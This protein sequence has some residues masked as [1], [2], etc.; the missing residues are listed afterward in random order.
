MEKRQNKTQDKIREQPA[1]KRLFFR[2][3]TMNTKCEA[4]DFSL[5]WSLK[6]HA[7]TAI[8]T[9][10]IM[11]QFPIEG[12]WGGEIKIPY[13]VTF[14][15]QFHRPSFL[16][17]PLE[18][19]LGCVLEAR[20]RKNQCVFIQFRFGAEVCGTKLSS[21]VYCCFLLCRGHDWRMFMS[22]ENVHYCFSCFVHDKVWPDQFFVLGSM[23]VF[24]Y[25]FHR[26]T[27]CGGECGARVARRTCRIHWTTGI[28]FTCDCFAMGNIKI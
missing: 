24:P 8:N 15:Q 4:Q 16:F 19:L 10:D 13:P 20:K 28:A 23:K 11:T 7:E 12:L 14:L 25:I 22:H 17:L 6:P 26:V 9:W 21:P 18:N 27:H 3:H 1:W 2:S 5:T